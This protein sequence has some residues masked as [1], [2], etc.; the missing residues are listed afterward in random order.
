MVEDLTFIT[1]EERKSLLDRFTTL[2]KDTRFF[3]CLV[4]YFYASGFYSLYKSLEKAEKIRVLIGISTDRSTFDMIQESRKEVQQRLPSSHK[5]TKDE[6]SNQVVKE[7]EN[8]KDSQEVEKGI[9]KFIEWLNSGKLEVKVYPAETIHAKLYITTFK[10]GDRDVGRV[11]TGSSNFTKSGL[12]DNI[13]FNVELKS[14]SDY[15]FSLKK[16]NELWEN[17][18]YKCLKNMVI[19]PGKYRQNF[20]GVF[21]WLDKRPCARKRGLGTT[22]P[23]D[24]DWIIE[25]LSDSTIYMSFYTIAH[26]IKENKITPEQLIPEVF[27]FVFLSK[28]QIKDVAE[29][30]KIP[31]QVIEKMKTEFEYWYPLDQR[32]TAIMHISNHLSF[33]IF[34]HSGIFPEKYWP[35]T[36]TL[37]E[38]VLVEGVKMGKS[39]GNVIPLAKISENYGADVFRLYMAYQAEFGAK[40]DWREENVQVV[41]KQLQKLYNLIYSVHPRESRE[42]TE[43]SMHGKAFLSKFTKTIKQTT[44]YIDN[45]DLRKY[46]Q[47]AFYEVTNAVIKYLKLSKKEEQNKILPKVFKNWLILLSPVI[48]YTC[49]EIWE[50]I[51][52]K[53]FVSLSK[54]PK[55]EEREID[56]EAEKKEEII[57]NLLEDIKVV[58]NLAK[59]KPKKIKIVVPEKWKYKLFYDLE[60]KLKETR[61][62]GKLMKEAMK[63]EEGRKNSKKIQKLVK[64][65]LNTGINVFNSEEEN[66]LEENKEFFEEEFGCEIE[67][68]KEPLKESWPGKFG[69]LVE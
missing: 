25:S 38:P 14:R 48:P 8:S 33:F 46:V 62:S 20:E 23:F 17:L 6:F 40:I 30:S 22:L 49:E 68:T 42:E 28:G 4:G 53:G 37:I 45:F 24:K 44:E 11:I 43:L 51:G 3:D 7:M 2:I 52:E 31:E 54:W 35:K 1:N 55:V 10:E 59:I 61:D 5:E 58:I 9:I 65:I 56:E 64:R 27:D 29:K 69:I 41:K 18:A 63:F 21:E 32:H 34:H 50:K 66:L 26:L 19:Y 67:I 15:E 39:K 13:E 60:K 47:T 12:R 36:I 16:F 57:L